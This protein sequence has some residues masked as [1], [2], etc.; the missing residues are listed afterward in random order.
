MECEGCWS[1]IS[2]N[3]RTYQSQCGCI[4]SSS[5]SAIMRFQ[6]QLHRSI[7]QSCLLIRHFHNSFSSFMVKSIWMSGFGSW[8]WRERRE[9][10]TLLQH[11]AFAEVTNHNVVYRIS[12]Q[13]RLQ[14]YCNDEIHFGAQMFCR[15]PTKR[16]MH[17]GFKNAI[18]PIAMLSWWY[19]NA[20]IDHF[21]PIIIVFC[22]G[23]DY[24]EK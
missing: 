10:R 17:W 8:W 16:R 9:I 20:N 24:F 12:P 3:K 5:R 15:Q 4:L 22:I 14:F 7:V 21:V 13:R 2:A 11:E 18:K 6:T 23:I 19:G 1:R